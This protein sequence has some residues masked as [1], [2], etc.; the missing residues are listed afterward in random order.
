MLQHVGYQLQ[1]GKSAEVSAKTAGKQTEKN[2]THPSVS[3]RGSARSRSEF[4]DGGSPVHGDY[5]LP[6]GPWVCKCSRSLT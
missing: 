1:R 5:Q 4:G 3:P 6:T 2:P